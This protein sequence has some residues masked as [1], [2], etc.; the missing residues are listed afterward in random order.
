[1]AALLEPNC[2]WN[3]LALTSCSFFA[4]LVASHDAQHVHLASAF[5]TAV[6]FRWPCYLQLT[7]EAMFSLGYRN[8][9]IFAP[10]FFHF[11]GCGGDK[12]AS[13]FFHPL[14][15]PFQRVFI[16]FFQYFFVP[17][18]HMGNL[19]HLTWVRHSSYKSLVWA[20]FLRVRTM[21]WIFNV[22]TDVDAC[23]CT[24]GLSRQCKR[25][26]TGIWLW[27]QNPLP[28][29]GLNRVSIKPGFFSQIR[30]QLSYP[31]P[32]SGWRTIFSSRLCQHLCRLISA[33]LAFVCTARTKIVVHVVKD[34]TFWCEKACGWLYGHVDL[35]VTHNSLRIIKLMIVAI[36]LFTTLRALIC[37]CIFLYFFF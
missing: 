26:W 32:R 23:H 8:T 27:E 12:S 2:S 16:T 33:C 7:V 15:A 4:P 3:H 17:Y 6:C 25:I 34:Y 35:H 18:H 36:L 31:G 24:Q 28:H 22:H 30:Y 29:W 11:W 20:V 9:C 14:I 37:V 5:N 19:G 1:M 13:S 10:V 21:V